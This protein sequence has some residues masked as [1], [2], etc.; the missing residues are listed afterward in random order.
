[1]NANAYLTPPDAQGF[2][3]HFDWMD[4]FVLQLHGS[5]RW[6]IYSQLQQYPSPDTKFKPT[7][8]ELGQPIADIILHPGKPID[9]IHVL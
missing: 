5:K 6:L 3:A 8:A 4:A 1:V 7:A 9:T 2:E